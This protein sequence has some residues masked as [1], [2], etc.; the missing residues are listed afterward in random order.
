MNGN[1]WTPRSI[2][3]ADTGRKIS[4]K[5]KASLERWHCGATG[6]SMDKDSKG[7]KKWEILVQDFF[8]QWKDTV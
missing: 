4:W 1:R 5:T 3:V 6:N 8:L 2:Q 7:Q